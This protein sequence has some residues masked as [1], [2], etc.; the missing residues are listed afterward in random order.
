[1]SL[2]VFDSRGVNGTAQIPGTRAD[3]RGRSVSID[4]LRNDR[5]ALKYRFGKPLALV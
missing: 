1:M 5:Q 3:L 4:R 2:I